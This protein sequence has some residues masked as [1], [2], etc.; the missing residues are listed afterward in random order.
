MNDLDRAIA[1]LLTALVQPR[2]MSSPAPWA[3]HT[4]FAMWLV[5]QLRPRLLVELGSYSGISYL[6]FCQAV[7][8]AGTMQRKERS[9]FRCI[10]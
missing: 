4:P 3:G 5:A 1:P 2:H 8:A 7:E 9:G 6:A 10:S